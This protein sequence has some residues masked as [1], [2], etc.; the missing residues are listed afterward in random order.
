MLDFGTGAV[1]FAEEGK[2]GNALEPFWEKPR[3]NKAKKIKA[4]AIDTICNFCRF[5]QFLH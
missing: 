5:M 3:R 2:G 1:V 4:V